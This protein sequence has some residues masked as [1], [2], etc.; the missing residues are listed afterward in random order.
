MPSIS[1]LWSLLWRAVLL[2][3]L[4]MVFGLFWLLIWVALVA[5]PALEILYLDAG[6]WLVAAVLPVLW[7][8]AFWLHHT[9][10]FK[11]DRHD[12][13]NEEENV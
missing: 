1:G 13:L 3:P 10:W 6:D 9:K 2:T 4:T 8:L 12:F 5:L 7:I 11:W